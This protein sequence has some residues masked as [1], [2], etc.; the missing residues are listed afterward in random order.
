[1]IGQM[2]NIGCLDWRDMGGTIRLIES[3]KSNELLVYQTRWERLL[4]D[5]TGIVLIYL[6]S[7]VRCRSIESNNSDNRPNKAYKEEVDYTKGKN[8]MHIP[9]QEYGRCFPLN[10]AFDLAIW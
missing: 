8:N 4:N 2:W 6:N 10:L 9:S 3:I 7:S 5:W 1:M